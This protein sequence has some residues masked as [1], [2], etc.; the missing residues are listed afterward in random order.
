MSEF[1]KGYLPRVHGQ[2]NQ[3][4]FWAVSDRFNN[5]F[6]GWFAELNTPA[7]KIVSDFTP[8]IEVKEDKNNYFVDVELAGIKPEEVNLDFHDKVLMIKGE[9]K[10]ERDEASADRKTHYTERFYGSFMRKIPFADDITEDKIDAE[11]KNGLLKVKLPKKP[12]DSPV[13]RKIEIKS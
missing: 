6:D 4:P 9:R 10:S 3:D 7:T 11:F 8:H 5:F 13:H 2:S 1:K 12:T